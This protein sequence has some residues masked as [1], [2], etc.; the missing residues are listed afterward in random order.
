MLLKR[1]FALCFLFG[2]IF[3]YAAEPTLVLD[4]KYWFHS[5]STIDGL[6]NNNVTCLLEDN[7]G[8]IWIGTESG[9]NIYDGYTVRQLS[10]GKEINTS[11]SDVVTSIQQDALGNVWVNYNGG[12]VVSLGINERMTARD[13]LTS[14]GVPMPND[15]YIYVDENGRLWILD[16]QKLYYYNLKNNRMYEFESKIDFSYHND[17]YVTGR[18]ENLYVSHHEELWHFDMNAKSWKKVEVPEELALTGERVKIY[19][20]EQGRKWLYSIQSELVFVQL[21][22]ETEW[23]KI[24]ITLKENISTQN[25][26][27]DICISK[28]GK[29]WIST[30]HNG[31]FIFDENLNLYK[32]VRSG[33]FKNEAIV[34][35][36]VV[37]MMC[38]HRGAIWLGHYKK[39]VSITHPS[40]GLF[41]NNDGEY[42]DVSAILYASDGTLWLGSD[43]YGLYTEK[44]RVVTKTPLPNTIVSDLV[45]DPDKSIWV[46]TFGDGIYNINGKFVK[47]YTVA[48]GQLLHDNAWHIRQDGEGRIW[49][50]SG[51]NHLATFDPK[52]GKSEEFRTSKDEPVTGDMLYYD[53]ESG[54]IYVG[55]YWG[56]CEIEPSGQEHMYFGDDD[57]EQQFLSYQISTLAIDRKNEVWWLGHPIGMTVWD[58]KND[59]LYFLNKEMGLCD[60]KIMQILIVDKDGTALVSTT[61]GLM[62]IS[63]AK[64]H[65]AL[66]FTIEPFSISDGLLD[67]YFNAAATLGPDN[68]AYFGSVSGYVNINVDQFLSDNEKDLSPKV[69]YC[70]VNGNPTPISALRNLNVDDHDID[71]Y[72]FTKEILDANSVKFNFKIEGMNETSIYS[73]DPKIHFLSL[74]PGEYKLNVRACGTDGV[75]SNPTV[76][77]ITVIAPFSQTKVM[78]ILYNVGAVLL[79]IVILLIIV[80]R[81]RKRLNKMREQYE[82]DAAEKVTDLKLQFYENLSSDLRK[83]VVRI[84]KRIDKIVDG[85]YQDEAVT[86]ALADMK[87]DGERLD[88]SLSQMLDFQRLEMG[89]EYLVVSDCDFVALAKDVHHQFEETVA[90][91]K[92]RY[93]FKTDAE[94][95]MMRCDE[96]KVRR[97]LSHLLSNAIKNSSAQ[98]KV[99]LSIT[100]D[101]KNLKFE[102]SDTGSGIPETEKQLIF[103]RFHQSQKHSFNTGGGIGLTLVMNYVKMHGGD[104]TF[105]DNEPHGTIFTVTLPLVTEA[106]NVVPAEEQ[107]NGS[108]VD[109]ADAGK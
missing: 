92:I 10:L 93:M 29:I 82:S 106:K 15:A 98:C 50:L 67:N 40:F 11:A 108:D 70:S 18:N 33:A 105:R 75:W 35:D 23:R 97:I 48:A 56:L 12:F 9:A 32:T 42:R 30:D 101:K 37:C 46:G 86:K 41:D 51:W 16:S 59:H 73:K 6:S 72:F 94:S 57:G 45:E 74:Q 13:Y 8:R 96:K 81:Y 78:K 31:V 19:L 55:T 90:K 7:K 36:N 79:A 80:W 89:G 53:K 27:R 47:K 99:F 88:Q 68:H 65:G 63:L 102:L 25:H 87:T 103:K 44:D 26:V 28:S 2:Y 54:N 52:T 49:Y 61:N 34:S 71:I 5:L 77:P 24:N 91:K 64:S 107:G 69:S 21:S 1:L 58:R 66:S 39:G 22:G 62:K 60:N 85:E 100:H 84:L 83:P 17:V 76:I 43:G 14:L 95:I 109:N 38:D 104:I 4:R 3:S 20:D